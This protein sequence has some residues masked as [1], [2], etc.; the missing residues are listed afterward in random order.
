MKKIDKKWLAVGVLAVVMVV[1]GVAFAAFSGMLTVRG[2]AEYNQDAA[3]VRW[4]VGS[5]EMS[6]LG[7]GS[8]SSEVL[9]NIS[10]NQLTIAS[11]LAQFSH[12]GSATLQATIENVGAQPA[13]VA[14]VNVP[15]ITCTA[16]EEADQ[17]FADALCEE[18][19]Y[20]FEYANGMPIVVGDTLGAQ[21]AV[22]VR[23]VIT[24]PAVPTVGMPGP[25][26]I[27]IGD[28][29]INYEG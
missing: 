16:Q 3:L 8:F 28:Q 10:S 23:V 13:E 15:A 26:A 9:A 20:V 24:L 6:S 7:G 22:D 17:I 18:L 14:A 1:G 5:I 19:T 25:V 2:S 29:T 27:A 21:S 11:Y 4:Q 12:A